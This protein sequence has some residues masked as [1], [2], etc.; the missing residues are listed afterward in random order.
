MGSNQHLT[1]LSAVRQHYA[2]AA[3]KQGESGCCPSEPRCCS[4][5]LPTMS[6]VE[7][8]DAFS[9]TQKDLENLPEDAFM[10]LGC[11]N[12]GAIASIRPGE[13][14]LD[15]GC[16]GGIDC[17]LAAKKAGRSG[18]VIG[19]DMT[20]EMVW[21]A[22]ENVSRHGYRNIDIRL[23]EIENLPLADQSADVIISNCVINLSQ[24][25]GRVFSEAFRV[26]KPG[27][28]L[29]I[30]DMVGTEPL[31]EDVRKDLSLYVGCVAGALFAENLEAL[32]AAAG[33]QGINIR[34]KESAPSQG[35]DCAQGTPL[36]G[37]VKPALVEAVKPDPEQSS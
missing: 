2:K 29:A 25:K 26:L 11:G 37:V 7:T 21:K 9:Y 3:E 35:N 23:G 17:F 6:D 36:V 27:G 20:P 31:T 30:A 19:V 18:T 12:P 13:T 4:P 1:L 34:F 28:R 16:G 22:R 10:G 24:D 5:H 32:L 15:L 8:T 14:V 33:F